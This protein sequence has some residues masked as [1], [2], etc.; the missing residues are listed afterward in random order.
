MKLLAAGLLACLCLAES[1]LER[2]ERLW[3]A[4]DYQEAN[5]AFRA[6]VQAAPRDANVR[7]RWGR[8]FLDRFNPAEAEKLFTEALAINPKHAGAMLGMALVAAESY[9]QKAVAMAEEALK[10]DPALR[11]ARQL[12]AK[13]A[14]EDGDYDRARDHSAKAQWSAVPTIIEWL[15]GRNA[16]MP[17]DSGSY[18]LAG[19]I[20]VLNRRYEEGIR[21]YQTAVEI[22]PKNFKARSQL[23]VNLM[24]LAR[25]KEAREQLEAAYAGGFR[26]A[27]T[28]NTLRL[29]D[30][31]SR[32]V[33][34]RTP[35]TIVRLHQKEADLLGPYVEGE[36]LRAIDTFEKKYKVRLPGPVQVEVYPDHEDFAVRT[37]GLPGLGALGVTFGSVVAMDSPSGRPA[38]T[39]HWA[40][41]L[42]HELSHVFVLTATKH[43]VP[44]WFTE[45]MAVHEETAVSKEWGDR[46]DPHVIS[47][48]AEKKLLPIADLDRGFVRP[49][50]PSQVTVS[51]FQAGRICD[52]INERW[53]YAKLLEMMRAFG[54]GKE[55]PDVVA[56]VLSMKP[57]EFD[58]AFLAWLDKQH[59]A[60]VRNLAEWKKAMTALQAAVKAKQHDAVLRDGPRVRDLYPDYVDDGNAYV[61]MA[62]AW[63]AT[64]KPAEAAA[65]LER[66]AQAGG[67]DP[68]TLGKLATLY[69]DAKNT[70]AAIRA[71]E[72]VLWVYPIDEKLHRRLG[73]LLLADG[74]SEK[75]IR[76]YQAVVAS[77]PIDQADA[78]FQLARALRASN[79]LEEAKDQL[80]LSLEAAPG[81]KPAQKMLLELSQ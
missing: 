26:D 4:R 29:M 81:F 63:I 70:K 76:E 59:G 69:A 8:L 72:R 53:G 30:S 54:S 20:F 71:L 23:G 80:F 22:D 48:I 61:A 32:F 11:E 39:F 10:V 47:A 6:A 9:D 79:R 25:E 3:A 52:Y 40:S 58:A 55:T 66:W 38:G 7:V 49:S 65:E 16:A 56:S 12:L 73:E 2:A 33:T 15:H 43:I 45:G 13:L 44:R 51:Y 67:R 17:R 19:H 42:W 24:R 21:Y 77:K 31:Y 75:A 36:L 57:A 78:R 37:M 64:G 1:P 68:E 74:Q 62:D 34:R 27:A 60:T 35:R 14:L 50:Y 28:V 41:T 18:E 5:E 46:L